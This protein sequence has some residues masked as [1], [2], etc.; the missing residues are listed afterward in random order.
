MDL[1]NFLNKLVLTRR[2]IEEPWFKQFKAIE[3][4]A[5]WMR[6]LDRAIQLLHDNEEIGEKF[7]RLNWDWR[8]EVIY[9]LGAGIASGV[10][11][12]GL[13]EKIDSVVET[14]RGTSRANGRGR[15]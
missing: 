6:S 5:A 3:G 13:G 7:N 12:D 4:S 11:E 1:K 2:I 8:Q 9:A 15:V 14:T 10:L